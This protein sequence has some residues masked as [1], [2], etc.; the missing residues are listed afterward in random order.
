MSEDGQTQ[1]PGTGMKIDIGQISA[2]GHVVISGGDAY[3][4]GSTRGDGSEEHVVTV[5]G[6]KASAE[7]VQELHRLLQQLDQK[8]EGARLEPTAQDAAKFNAATLKE[9][10]SSESR[11][12]EHLLVQATEAL[13]NY[14]PDI[15]GAVV[16]TFTIPL[17][18]KIT[19]LA[20][21]RALELYRRLR[22]SHTHTEQSSEE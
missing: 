3:V 20:G 12:N 11:P 18:G 7:E 16:A 8:I 17:A 19:A 6:V 5:G 15:A 13:L 14:G 21:K 2:A 9:Q 22:A 10:L 4:T 1:S